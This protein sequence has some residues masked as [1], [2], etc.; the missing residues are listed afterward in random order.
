MS[1][2]KKKEIELTCSCDHCN[3]STHKHSVEC[4]IIDIC[5][6][7]KCWKLICEVCLDIHKK[8]H[9]QNEIKFFVKEK[10]RN[11]CFLF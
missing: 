8:R 5:K 1:N 9:D 6:C 11:C 7:E 4:E 3:C 10:K 2:E